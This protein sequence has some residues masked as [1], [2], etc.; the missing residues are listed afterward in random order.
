M[1]MGGA[2]LVCSSIYSDKTLI[3][4]NFKRT[5]TVK[6]HQGRYLEGGIEAE[7]MEEH[8]ACFLIQTRTTSLGTV[9]ATGTC[10]SYTQSS[11][12]PISEWRT[13]FSA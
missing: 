9:P 4:G 6:G 2:V 3:Q 8:E 12:P 13:W 10:P 7:A 5:R 1:I 11:N